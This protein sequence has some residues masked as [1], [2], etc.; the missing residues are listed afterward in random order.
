MCAWQLDALNTE[1]E[2]IRRSNMRHKQA[3]VSDGSELRRVD[4]ALQKYKKDNAAAREI[5]EAQTGRLEI[6][7]QIQNTAT[8]LTQK[9]E[10]QETENALLQK[11]LA[12][13]QQGIAA[14]RS[15][16]P[17]LGAQRLAPLGERGRHVD[18]GRRVHLALRSDERPVDVLGVLRRAGQRAANQLV[19]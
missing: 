16:G 9:L 2:Q 3:A 5:L 13:K 10:E 19:D 8:E 11:V 4:R 1:L 12:R 15:S 14:H 17:D 6:V 7:Q 18:E